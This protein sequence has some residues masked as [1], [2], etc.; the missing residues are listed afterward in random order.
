MDCCPICLENKNLVKLPSCSH[1]LCEACKKSCDEHLITSCPLCR[2]EWPKSHK[3]KMLELLDLR[4]NSLIEFVE[5][6][7]EMLQQ[8]LNII[9]IRL[10]LGIL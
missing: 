4:L 3:Q 1:S 6:N 10:I 2:V 9:T 5:N 8:C 7:E